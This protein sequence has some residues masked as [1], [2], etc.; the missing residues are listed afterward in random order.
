MRFQAEAVYVRGE[1]RFQFVRDVLLGGVQRAFHQFALDFVVEHGDVHFFVVIDAVEL[2]FVG[3]VG[4]FEDGNRA[5]GGDGVDV[6]ARVRCA[7]GLQG[8]G[9]VG[10]VA[11]RAKQYRERA[12]AL[13]PC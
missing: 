3:G 8:G 1:L 6:V 5:V 12:P 10:V 13:V 11:A 7:E 2:P 9:V 4:V